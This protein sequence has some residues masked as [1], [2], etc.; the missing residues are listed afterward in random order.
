MLKPNNYTIH[1]IDIN[2]TGNGDGGF[3]LMLKIT[4]HVFSTT[5]DWQTL[6]KGTKIRLIET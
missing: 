1:T 6:N 3:L 2:V 4:R 5:N